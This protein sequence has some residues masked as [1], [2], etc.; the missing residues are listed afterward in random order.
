MI[1]L[2]FS[3]KATSMKLKNKTKKEHQELLALIISN[4]TIYLLLTTSHC[5]FVVSEYLDK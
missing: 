2:S 1:F 5:V 4:V 3:W